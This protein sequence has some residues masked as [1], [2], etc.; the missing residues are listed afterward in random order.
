MQKKKSGVKKC[1]EIC[2]IKGGGRTPNGKCHLKFPFWFFD[3]VPYKNTLYF[4]CITV[5]IYWRIK[6][7]FSASVWLLVKLLTFTLVKL[8]L[9]EKICSYSEIN[10][11]AGQHKKRQYPFLWKKNI[12]LQI[13][14]KIQEQKLKNHYQCFQG[15]KCKSDYS[16]Q[17]WKFYVTNQ[18]RFA[19]PS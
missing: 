17:Q 18:V 6:I 1:L 3:S 5:N 16:I 7:I 15:I 8:K 2:A 13:I 4:L 19:F 11:K 9:K 12:N 10:Y 14:S